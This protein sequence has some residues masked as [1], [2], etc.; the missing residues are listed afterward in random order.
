MKIMELENNQ[1]L[2]PSNL[3]PSSRDARRVFI[4]IRVRNMLEKDEN[5][6]D[7]NNPNEIR[8]DKVEEI[9]IALETDIPKAE[10]AFDNI[11]NQISNDT[12]HLDFNDPAYREDY[13]RLATRY[14]NLRIFQGSLQN[15]RQH[16]VR[17][18]VFGATADNPDYLG[19][20]APSREKLHRLVDRRLRTTE[21]ML[22]SVSTLWGGRWQGKMKAIRDNPAGPWK[23]GWNRIFEYPR[24]PRRNPRTHQD[25]FEGICNPH[26]DEPHFCQTPGMMDWR[27][28]SQNQLKREIAVNQNSTNNWDPEGSYKFFLKTGVDPIVAINEIFKGKENFKERNLLFCD[29]VIHLLHLEAFIFSRRNSTSWLTW[30]RNEIS[31][32]PKGWFRIWKSWSD[33][34]F[35]AGLGNPSKIFSMRKIH[36]SQLQVGDHF[37]MYLHP[38]YDNA[39]PDGYWRLENAVVVMVGKH[40]FVQGHG[41]NPSFA[42]SEDI[43]K[44]KRRD[45]EKKSDYNLNS[46]KGRMIKKFN[47]TLDFLRRKVE[48]RLEMENP[49]P[50]IQYGGN[51]VLVRR[52][53]PTASDFI[54]SMQKADWW[55]RWNPYDINLKDKYEINFIE[56]AENRKLAWD[57][58]KIKYYPFQEDIHAYFPLWEPNG[59]PNRAGKITAIKPVL[60]SHDM[61]AA[62]SW[63]FPKEGN[64]EDNIMVIRPDEGVLEPGEL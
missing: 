49:E 3:A 64:A 7:P 31:S 26:P 47:N 53:E 17:I 52:K 5:Y 54:P 13:K 40:L 9:K 48:S 8:D 25:F 27:I 24:I 11:W 28:G 32:K 57:R 20:S 42:E 63:F 55:L 4:R 39:S 44:P 41:T 58:H 30:L 62:W 61:V 36:K 37:I 51:G 23:D 12:T 59:P 1:S 46:M 6:R 38:A 34:D 33:D 35:L 22:F 15:F 18:I 16:L 14:R 29:H 50:E 43:P 2:V 19:Q 60:I 10:I 45:R 21:R 56:D